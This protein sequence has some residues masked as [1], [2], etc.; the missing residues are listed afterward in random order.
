MLG[1]LVILLL[2]LWPV[3][4]PTLVHVSHFV[5]HRRQHIL[6]VPASLLRG[7]RWYA[8]AMAVRAVIACRSVAD[9]V[10]TL[11]VDEVVPVEEH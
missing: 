10:R 6:G 9:A 3:L 1:G 7:L 2:V 8:A 4:I 11:M 5:G